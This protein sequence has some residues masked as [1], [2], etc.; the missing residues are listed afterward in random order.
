MHRPA[1]E[2]ET[3]MCCLSNPAE[4]ELSL[5]LHSSSKH[6]NQ[7]SYGSA[8]EGAEAPKGAKGRYFL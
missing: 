7:F 8:A 4:A 5:T 3:A 2:E 1:L 6:R